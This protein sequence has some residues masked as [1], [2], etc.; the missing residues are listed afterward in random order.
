[1]GGLRSFVL[2]RRRVLSLGASG[3]A[4]FTSSTTALALAGSAACSSRILQMRSCFERIG[5]LQVEL[6]GDLLEFGELLRSARDVEH[7]SVLDIG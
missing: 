2:H 3:T 4:D 7:G 6:L 1:M 5:L